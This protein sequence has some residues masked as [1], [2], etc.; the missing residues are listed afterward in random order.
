MLQPA[1]VNAFIAA[2]DSLSAKYPQFSKQLSAMKPS[3][4]IQSFVNGTMGP[5][6]D[7]RQNPGNYTIAKDSDAWCRRGRPRMHGGG[8]TRSAP[9][10]PG[11]RASGPSRRDRGL[12]PSSDAH[13]LTRRSPRCLCAGARRR[14]EEPEAERRERPLVPPAEALRKAMK[15]QGPDSR[16]FPGRSRSGSFRR[17]GPSRNPWPLSNCNTSLDDIR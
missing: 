2:L 3:A 7:F 17:P 14:P 6:D 12:L 5:I 16:A 8:P 13:R 1:R 15:R 11:P 4:T 9:R 10:R